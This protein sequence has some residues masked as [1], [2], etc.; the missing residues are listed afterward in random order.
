MHNLEMKCRVH[1]GELRDV[2]VSLE[3][4]SIGDDQYVLTMLQ[5]ITDRKRVEE[6][7]RESE[8]FSHAVV[9]ALAA[10]VAILDENGIIVAVNK[11]WRESRATNSL[12]KTDMGEGDNYLSAWDSVQ[13]VGRVAGQIVCSRNSC[14]HAW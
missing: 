3:L 1:S 10:D 4:L 14:R 8:Q 5:D 2:L 9:D 13:D 6:V 12:L 7:L 11:A